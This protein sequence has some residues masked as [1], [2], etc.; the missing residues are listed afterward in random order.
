[1]AAN[2]GKSFSDFLRKY[3]TTRG[4]T[5]K[6]LADLADMGLS[7]LKKYESDHDD[8][9]PRQFYVRA[10]ADALGL[11]DDARDEFI[12]LSRKERAGGVD[13][14]A[15][16]D[17]GLLE[18]AEASSRS[19]DDTQPLMLVPSDVTPHSALRALGAM[20]Q[21]FVTVLY[22]HY[23]GR[24]GRLVS[25]AIALLVIAG[26]AALV[27]AA[28]TPQRADNVSGYESI[29]T[30]A[31]DETLCAGVTPLCQTVTG[32]VQG[33]VHMVCWQDALGFGGKQNRW[34][35]IQAPDGS[36]GFVHAAAVSRQIITPYCS[37][38][39]WMNATAWALNQ[40]GQT[41]I[42]L[43][44]TNSNNAKYRASSSWLFAYDAWR[45]GGGHT[46]VHSA[47]TAQQTWE[48]YE[49][50]GAWHLTSSMPPRGSLVF[51]SYNNVGR[52]ALALGN[53]LVE[54]AQDTDDITDDTRLRPVTHMSIAQVGL[55]QLGYVPPI[56]V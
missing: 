53:G 1:M 16:D 22:N 33:S 49:A 41:T 11:G 42:P 31:S 36:E 52:V 34:F 29:V 48:M 2:R 14:P 17:T 40:D 18:S 15:P 35:Y 38:I 3:R 19:L 44:A 21:E 10:L 56:L 20:L 26:V 30:Y 43:A 37:K 7:T 6:E 9:T 55:P 51:F 46:P 47:A 50:S 12:G 13:T 23:R 45:L 32:S 8:S 39:P 4:L 25:V 54:I 27:L 28:I 24:P 5:Q